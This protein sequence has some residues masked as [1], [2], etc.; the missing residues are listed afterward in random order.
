MMPLTKEYDVLVR[1]AGEHRRQFLVDC[2]LPAGQI[3]T[4]FEALEAAKTR[5]ERL[6]KYIHKLEDTPY[7]HRTPDWAAG[8]PYHH[9]MEGLEEEEVE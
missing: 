5:V 4:V 1:I 2:Y 7:R 3:L 6:E 8:L 9:K